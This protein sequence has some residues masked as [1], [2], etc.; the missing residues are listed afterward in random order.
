MRRV[1]LFGVVFA[2]A[3]AVEAP[4]RAQSLTFSLFDRYLDSLRER[5]GVPGLSALISQNGTIG[6]ERVYGRQ[7]VEASSATPFETAYPIGGLSQAI[8]STLLL[9]KCVDESYAELSNRVI[10][11][12]PDYPDSTTTIE[13]LLT[14]TSPA[15]QFLYSPV[16]FAGVTAVI[17]Q[18]AGDRYARLVADEIFDR[19]GMTSTVPGALPTS[20][21][22]A[23]FGDAELTRYADVIRR[24]AVPYRVDS[25]QRPT[26]SEIAP[27]SANA[28]TGIIST[29]RD[30]QRFDAALDDDGVLLEAATR[31]SAWTQ[32]RSGTT[33]LPTGWGWFVQE[34]QGQPI[35]WQ[36]GTVPNVYSSLIIK[37][38]NRRLTLILL[39][40]SDGL[41]A[42]FALENGDLTRSLFAQLF[43]Q[44][45]V[46]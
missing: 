27:A 46:P 40:N 43:L 2:A 20:T 33:A 5:T 39:A 35:V 17:E 16:R 1:A 23:A 12:D 18:C 13:Q 32:K 41:N 8:G 26:R 9:K 25:Q 31:V 21:A 11:W 7:N 3:L 42:P 30:L 19:L 24:L 6:W 38:P 36:F 10:R 29:A 14:H 22:A 37:A 45:L 28:A 44:L 34:Y 4:V 15:G